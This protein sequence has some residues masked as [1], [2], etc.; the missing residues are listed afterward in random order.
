MLIGGGGLGSEKGEGVVP[1]AGS[2]SGAARASVPAAMRPGGS[3]GGAVVDGLDAAGGGV[4]EPEAG[5]EI[6]AGDMGAPAGDMGPPTGMPGAI[7]IVGI[8]P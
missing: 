4:A 5:E 2:D 3:V 6:T 8:M 1:G 7:P